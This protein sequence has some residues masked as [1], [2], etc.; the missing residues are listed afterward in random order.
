MIIS[1]LSFIW[2]V[3]LIDVLP[4]VLLENINDVLRFL[5]IVIQLDPPKPEAIAHV[6]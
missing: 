6:F 3:V 5:K 4:F 2:F 1:K